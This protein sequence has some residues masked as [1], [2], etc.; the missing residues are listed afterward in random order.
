MKNIFVFILC[1]MC[2]SCTHNPNINNNP[3]PTEGQKAMIDRK[4]GMFLHFGMN[5]YLNMEW[6][7]GKA[8]PGVY[9]PPSDIA[10]K[11]AGWVRNAKKAGMRSIVLTTKHHDGFC[12]WDSELTD[13]D[14]ANEE[15]ENNID[16][17]KAVSDE[18]RKQGIAFS[19]YYSLW[20]RHEPSYKDPDHYKYIGFMKGQLKELMTNYGP[21]AELWFDGAW[22]RSVEKW[23]LEEIYD[24]VKQYQPD[25]QISTNWTIGKR[26]VDMME[27]DSIVYFPSDFRLWD[28]FLP[29][30]DDPKIYTHKGKKYYLPFECTQTMS[31]LGN[32]FSHPEDTLMRGVDELYE[33]YYVSTRNDNC[34]L[35]NLPPDT[36]GNQNEDALSTV[37]KLADIVGIKDGKDFPEVLEKPSSKTS[38][39]VASSTG[40]YKNDTLHYG[41]QYAVDADVSTCWQGDSLS[42]I[43]IDLKSVKTFDS[44]SIITGKGS[45]QKFNLSAGKDGV[46]NSLY[47]GVINPEKEL[48]SFMGYGYVNIKLPASVSADIVKISIEQSN[49]TPSIYS[50]RLN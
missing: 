35:V 25:C 6:S 27:G 11:A 20:D 40:I 15:V 2:I 23:H 45:I 50:L 3:R 13:Y 34:L 38:E 4:Y 46:I 1:C 43:T 49:G 47:D 44:V 33:I 19:V 16:I 24:W 31:I 21:V 18:C 29:V 12:L 17:V 30:H 39:A 28:P 8:L 22:D 14:I 9:A 41:P 36:E 5:T 37:F 42:S 7:D 32:W 10:E 26:P 48:S